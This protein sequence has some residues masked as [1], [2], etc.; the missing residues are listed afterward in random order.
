MPEISARYDPS[1]FNHYDL[2]LLRDGHRV[3]MVTFDAFN[4]NLAPVSYSFEN[5]HYVGLSQYGE[6][7]NNMPD[8]MI[9]VLLM[10]RGGLSSKKLNRA[11]KALSEEVYKSLQPKNNISVKLFAGSSCGMHKIGI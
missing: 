4:A 9:H 5:V 1:A 6:G 10:P 8:V 2:K 11:A 3:R 7:S